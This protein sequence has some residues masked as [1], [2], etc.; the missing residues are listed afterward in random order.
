MA[1]RLS[2]V[3]IV[4]DA[5]AYM[6]PCLESFGDHVDEIVCVDTGSRDGTRAEIRRVA[7]EHGW[8]DKLVLDRFRWCDDFAAARNYAESLATC[9]FACKIDQDETVRGAEALRRCCDFL[10]PDVGE[11]TGANLLLFETLYYGRWGWWQRL[12]RTGAWPY[13]FKVADPRPVR[14]GVGT[15]GRDICHFIHHRR[16]DERPPDRNVKVARKWMRKDPADPSATFELI[17]ELLD[18]RCGP[19]EAVSVFRS[20]LADYP[21]RR[22]RLE[23]LLRDYLPQFDIERARGGDK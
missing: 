1:P 21:R 13:V 19:D 4:R 23:A 9:E 12:A 16:W 2:M 18:T 7:R 5:G 3:M 15:V 14:G 17:Y 22:R 6:R 20:Y 10:T 11:A 8:T